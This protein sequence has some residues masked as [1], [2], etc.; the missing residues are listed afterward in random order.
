MDNS[1]GDFVLEARWATRVKREEVEY[2]AL[3]TLICTEGHA[4]RVV[5]LERLK[6]AISWLYL[7]DT[8]TGAF[9]E[10]NVS[11]G[12]GATSCEP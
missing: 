5:G 6:S 2:V 9:V 7:E 1:S 10:H 8:Q 3:G 4:Y 12:L 11:D